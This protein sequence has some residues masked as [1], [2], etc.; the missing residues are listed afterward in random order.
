MP[1]AFL[2]F[3]G[4]CVSWYTLVVILV[5]MCIFSSE[6]PPH[7]PH[8]HTHIEPFFTFQSFLW[9][10]AFYF[11][12]LLASLQ[13][14]PGIIPLQGKS[15]DDLPLCWLRDPEL[16]V[17]VGGSRDSV[18]ILSLKGELSPDPGKA[19]LGFW[20]LAMWGLSYLS[21][22]PPLWVGTRE[23]IAWGVNR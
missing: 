13:K 21:L 19:G 1:L 12:M 18:C 8:T 5:C 22:F 10:L 9:D 16:K 2:Y 23:G 11:K 14:D 15:Q 4:S 3:P 7:P 20:G 17:G 6:V